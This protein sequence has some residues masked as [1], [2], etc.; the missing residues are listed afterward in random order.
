LGMSRRSGHGEGA[1]NDDRA[2]GTKQRSS[3]HITT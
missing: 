1:G 3:R 2:R